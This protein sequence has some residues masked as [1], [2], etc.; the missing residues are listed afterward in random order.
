[1]PCRKGGKLGVS[2]EKGIGLI[3]ISAVNVIG[4]LNDLVP[5]CT[6]NLS[7]EKNKVYRFRR[8]TR[9][10]HTSKQ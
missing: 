3:V 7:C 6:E 1:M 10:V 8:K 9:Y 2:K 5:I 4:L